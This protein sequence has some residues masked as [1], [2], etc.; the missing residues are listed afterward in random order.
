MRSCRIIHKNKVTERV[1]YPLDE[2]ESLLKDVPQ[3]LAVRIRTVISESH[4]GPPPQAEQ[5]E[6]YGKVS[7]GAAKEILG[8]A[9]EEQQIRK[10]IIGL[11][12]TPYQCSNAV[13]FGM[14]SLAGI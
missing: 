6:Q 4:S 7:P 8:M 9:K 14:I 13:S 12:A 10:M 2:H 1:E 3:E 5:F 11:E